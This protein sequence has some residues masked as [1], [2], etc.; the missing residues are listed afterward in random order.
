MRIALALGVT[1]VSAC[2]LNVGYLI[3]HS[4]VRTLPPLSVR[5]PLRA[6]RLLLG[7]RR[8]VAGFAVEGAGWALYVLALAL[9]P[10][11]LVQA[12]AAGG[13][14]ILAVMVARLTGVPLSAREWAAV[15]LAVAGLA[16]LGVSLAGGHGE[17]AAAG[18]LPVGLWLAASAGAAAVAIRLL[19][20]LVGAGAAFGLAT[21]L[22][23]AAG[24]VATKSA[25]EEGGHVAFVAAL[26]ACYAAGTGVL[27]AG[28]QR[29]DP[30]TTAGIATLFTNALPIAAGM[31]I[32]GEPLPGG[33]LGAVRIVAF[34]AVVAGAV[35]LGRRKHGQRGELAG[36]R[37]P[38]QPSLS[39]YA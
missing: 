7:N 34:A 30:L 5:R 37:P 8:W 23:F 25:V 2:A 16:L 4:V 6:A 17:G 12:A 22:L 33:W 13:V 10:L 11:S 27:Q 3:E 28:F 38:E 31:T 14:G 1:L 18:A 36:K 32:F 26:L 19:P 20:R 15:A 24:D 21:G 9:A 35:V 39:S 29:G